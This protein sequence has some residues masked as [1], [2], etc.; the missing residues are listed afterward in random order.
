MDTMISQK[1]VIVVSGSIVQ[2]VSGIRN[3][4]LTLKSLTTDLTTFSEFNSFS[5]SL[6]IH[7]ESGASNSTLNVRVVTGIETKI[8]IFFSK[9]FF[10]F[11]AFQK[12]HLTQ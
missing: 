5:D 10:F 8:N 4:T 3:K 7:A 1:A 12:E 9:N 6:S 11:F 2:H